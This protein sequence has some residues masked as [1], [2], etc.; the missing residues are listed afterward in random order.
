MYVKWQKEQN[1]TPP[2]PT[3][4]RPKASIA[5]GLVGLLFV[6]M[7]GSVNRLDLLYSAGSSSPLPATGPNITT[8]ILLAIAYFAGTIIAVLGR[9]LPLIIIGWGVIVACMF[10]FAVVIFGP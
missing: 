2:A 5:V 7:L 3:L 9:K 4:T 8:L 10:G 1:S 6:S